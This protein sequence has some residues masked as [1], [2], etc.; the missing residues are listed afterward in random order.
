M[1]T[2]IAFES[3]GSTVM[4]LLYDDEIIVVVGLTETVSCPNGLFTSIGPNVFNVT[5]PCL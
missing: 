3:K 4:I 1:L 5:R 2:V